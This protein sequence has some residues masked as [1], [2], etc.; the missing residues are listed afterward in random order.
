MFQAETMFLN[1]LTFFNIINKLSNKGSKGS[2]GSKEKKMSKKGRFVILHP[3]TG[4]RLCKDDLWRGFAN[5]GTYPSCV[6]IYKNF[7]NATKKAS[8][9]HTNGKVHVINLDAYENEVMDASG[10]FV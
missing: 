3:E 7:G 2:K 8:K 4:D 5:F 10:K 6:K 1:L 9:M